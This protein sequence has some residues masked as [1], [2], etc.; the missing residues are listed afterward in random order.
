MQS[1]ILSSKSG[2]FW[3]LRN[4]IKNCT[5]IAKVKHQ[6][7]GQSYSWGSSVVLHFVS[8]GRRDKAPHNWNV[9]SHSSGEEKSETAVVA[10]PYSLWKLEGILLCSLLAVGGFLAITGI[11]WHGNTSL[12]PSMCTW[13]SLRGSVYTWTTSDAIVPLFVSFFHLQ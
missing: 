5:K 4:V 11:P 1:K 2:H 7:L 9:L 6:C 12:Q 13:P 3:E 10:G 8:P